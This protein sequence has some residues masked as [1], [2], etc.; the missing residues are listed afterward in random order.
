MA[1]TLEEIQQQIYDKIAETPQLSGLTSTSR[2][3]I[4]RLWVYII[5]FAIWLHEEIVEANAENS[6]PHT[7]RWYREQALSFLDGLELVWLDGQ[8][9]YET[10]GVTN[11]DERQII[12]RC[13]V[14]ESTDGELIIKIATELDDQVQPITDDQ[15]LRFTSYMNQIKDTGN[16]LVIVNRPPDKLKLTL[17]VYVDEQIINLGDGVLLN[18]DETI[19][20]VEVAVNE[21]LRN[22]EFNG[23]LVKEF[24][25]DTIQKDEGVKLPIIEDLQWQYAGL[26][27]QSI[28]QWQVPDAG[29][30][31]IEELTINYLPYALE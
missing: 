18:T 26:P 8:F 19:K 6:R 23:A 2:V 28:D 29:Y 20:P 7:L 1:R 17:K 14:L 30:F 9:Q 21:H 16:R 4:W 12:D 10:E 15:L 3:A 25:R 13:A 24:L 27:F 31:E 22:L 11:L 5:A